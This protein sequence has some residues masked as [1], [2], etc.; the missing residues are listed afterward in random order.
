[1]IWLPNYQ[2]SALALDL[3]QPASPLTMPC[4]PSDHR[5]DHCL[6]FGSTALSLDV[7]T[8]L[9]SSLITINFHVCIPSLEARHLETVC[10]L[11]T[12]VFPKEG[13]DCIASPSVLTQYWTQGVQRTAGMKDGITSVKPH[14][15]HHT[16]RTA[17]AM[18]RICHL[19]QKPQQG[20]W[21]HCPDNGHRWSI[22]IAWCHHQGFKKF[23][24]TTGK[25][26]DSSQGLRTY[27]KRTIKM[28][29]THWA[30]NDTPLTLSYS[31]GA[32]GGKSTCVKMEPEAAI[33]TKNIIVNLTEEH[34]LL[35]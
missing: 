18:F 25:G 14:Q 24:L 35:K 11:G 20:L 17:A 19:G 2:H 5:V 6:L 13:P 23:W 16:K 3:A 28:V 30:H 33:R 21:L 15:D 1:M 32:I 26:W 29:L 8:P 34:K 10:I 9:A 27:I 31:Y 4:F 12:G 22:P 7:I